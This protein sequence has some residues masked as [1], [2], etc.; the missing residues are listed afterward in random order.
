MFCWETLGHSIN[1][2]DT[3]RNTHRN[4]LR[5][6][7]N[8]Q[9]PKNLIFTDNFRLHREAASQFPTSKSSAVNDPLLDTTGHSHRILYSGYHTSGLNIVADHNI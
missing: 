3:P 8:R 5:C 6:L 7:P 4:G 9:I 2:D 1:V